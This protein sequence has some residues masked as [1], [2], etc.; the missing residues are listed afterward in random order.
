MTFRV[1]LPLLL[2]AGL[3]GAD[4]DFLRWDA[5]QA[6]TI[7]LATRVSGQVGKSLDFRV[8]GTDRSYNYKLRAT[9]MTPQVIRAVARL[10]QLATALTNEE[11]RKLVAEAEAAGEIVVQV[12]IDPREGS[13]VIPNDWVALLG[14]RT[15]PGA[16]S[17]AVRGASRPKLRDLPALA[18]GVPRDYSYEVFWVVFPAQGE[19]GQP[20]FSPADR[21]AEL[22]VRIGGKVGKVRWPVPE[23]IRGKPR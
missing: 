18:G 16:A 4:D 12:E 5:K 7:A 19:D 21:E 8:T 11:T 22:S 15:E 20:L 14:T 17:R 3:P 1:L 2:A 13:G 10:Q 9:W 6:R 23:Y